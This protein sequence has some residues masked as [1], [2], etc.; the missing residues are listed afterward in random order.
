MS[1]AV[2]PAS[3][4]VTALAKVEA[5]RL[6]RH[7]FFV[8]G[9]ILCVVT[10]AGTK[11]DFDYYNEAVDPAFFIGVFSMIAT[12]RLTRSMEKLEE[13]VGSTPAGVQDHVRAL[14]LACLLPATLGVLA[15]AWI[16]GFKEVTEPLAYGAWGEAD[17]VGIFFGSV[18][19]ACLGGP[20]LG[21]AAARWLRFPG[22]VVALVIGILFLVL[23]GEGLADANPQARWAALL[24][25]AAP[26]TQFT[27]VN[28]D[29]RQIGSWLGSPWLWVG[30][31]VALCVLAVL[32]ALL[33]GAEG[34]ERQRLFRAGLVTGLVGLAFLGL[35]TFLGPDEALLQT[36]SGVATLTGGAVSG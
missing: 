10:I 14:Q 6:A 25:L 12:F 27:T 23:A 16:L 18:V 17:R 15:F 26:W 1:S 28:S 5:L 13:A 19:V 9:V 31:L 24:R 4:S 8:V 35:A 22:A 3:R 2:M 29:D 34:E 30:W 36:P 20:L 7:P 21:I 33:K 11:P 32:G